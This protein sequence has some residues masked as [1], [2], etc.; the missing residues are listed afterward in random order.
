MPAMALRPSSAALAALP[1]AGACGKWPL[2]AVSR[3][4]SSIWAAC[5]TAADGSGVRPAGNAASD[6]SSCTC[7]CSDPGQMSANHMRYTSSS[8]YASALDGFLHMCL[9][10]RGVQSHLKQ[11]W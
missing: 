6:A 8:L 3:W 9:L 10:L 5:A 2:V 4:S 7:A 1:G 11:V